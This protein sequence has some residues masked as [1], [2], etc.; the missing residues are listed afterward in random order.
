MRISCTP[1]CSPRHKPTLP[2][3]APPG[4]GAARGNSVR[5]RPS[6]ACAG[7]TA[8]GVVAVSASLCLPRAVH[9]YERALA[10]DR[11]SLELTRHGR[12]TSP[13]LKDH[14]GTPAAPLIHLSRKA[15]PITV[16]LAD[17]RMALGRDL[18]RF[19][20]TGARGL[21]LDEC[22]REVLRIGGEREE[23]LDRTGDISASEAACEAPRPTH[24]RVGLGPTSSDKKYSCR[25][26]SIASVPQV[27]SSVHVGPPVLLGRVYCPP[28]TGAS[29]AGFRA[30]ARPNPRFISALTKDAGRTKAGAPSGPSAAGAG[31][32][33]AGVERRRLSATLSSRLRASVA[34]SWSSGRS[35]NRPAERSRSGL[36]K[37]TKLPPSGQASTVTLQGSSNPISGAL[38][39]AR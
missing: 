11:S 39:S 3:A 19:S 27:R 4:G 25:N 34:I 31:Y 13:A 12:C 23:S 26:P 35:A 16:E 29:A 33:A 7:L 24:F 32:S 18:D 5:V 36:T 37:R 8:A 22:P 38:C 6:A 9:P 10:E 21:L 17:N 30:R 2:L 15:D 14:N 28:T 20:C 1:S